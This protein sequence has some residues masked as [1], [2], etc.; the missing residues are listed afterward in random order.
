MAASCGS[1]GISGISPWSGDG[2]ANKVRH[3][4][5]HPRA[6]VSINL[7]FRWAQMAGHCPA[8]PWGSGLSCR[9]SLKKYWGPAKKRCVRTSFLTIF[10]L[11]RLCSLRSSQRVH[12]FYGCPTGRMEGA[13]NGKFSS[14]WLRSSCKWPWDFLGSLHLQ[15]CG[16][17]LAAVNSCFGLSQQEP[18]VSRTTAMSPGLLG[19]HS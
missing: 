4:H 19:L 3:L 7:L 16:G 5:S 10:P 1:D 13:Q 8:F 11:P 18:R 12:Y 2:R 17:N 6:T 9:I 15:G 14:L